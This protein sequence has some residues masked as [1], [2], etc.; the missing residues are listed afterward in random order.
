M[1]CACPPHPRICPTRGCVPRS[2]VVELGDFAVPTRNVTT[3]RSS[4]TESY[5][6]RRRRENSGSRMWAFASAHPVGPRSTV[7]RMIS[8]HGGAM[9]FDD[10]E[11][12][13]AFRRRGVGMARGACG[14]QNGPRR[15]VP[16]P[17]ASRLCTSLL[18]WQ[19]TLYEGGWGA[20]TWPGGLW[21]AGREPLAPGHLRPADGQVRRLDRSVRRRHRD[22]RARLLIA[23]G[24][25][26]QKRR[27]LP[28]MLRG[29]AVWCSCSRNQT[30]DPTWRG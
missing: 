29:E 18:A 19:H 3:I 25:E 21:R 14:D 20:I 9:D 23:H 11:E 10:T 16:Q 17:H 22:G 15:L 7:H 13:A 12:D 5:P 28:A 26:E 27:Y 8:G 6:K 4:R 2:R 24:S 30:P 1:H